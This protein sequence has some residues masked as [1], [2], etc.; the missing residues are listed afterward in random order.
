[1]KKLHSTLFAAM[2]M[3]A[4]FTL[5]TQGAANAAP[6]GWPT[7]CSY[8]KFDNGWEARCTNSNGG[9]YKATVTCQPL[10]GGALIVRDATVWKTSGISYVFCPPMSFVKGGGIITKS[11]R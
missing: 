4:C 2:G 10:D 5:G 7:G 1:M 6:A 8:G 9:S 11:T 3:A